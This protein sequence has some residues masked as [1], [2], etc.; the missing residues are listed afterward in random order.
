MPD[1]GKAGYPTRVFRTGLNP[2]TPR[3]NLKFS[4]PLSIQL[5]DQ[6]II[7]KLIVFFILITCLLDIVLIL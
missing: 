7:P 1:S 4:L 5:L 3:P 6:P 2:S